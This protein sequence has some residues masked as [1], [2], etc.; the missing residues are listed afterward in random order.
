MSGFP[1]RLLFVLL[2]AF[3]HAG[4][5]QSSPA[6]CAHFS[7]DRSAEARKPD[8]ELAEARCH[9]AVR[10]YG[11]A[12][13]AVERLLALQPGD[14]VGLALREIVLESLRTIAPVA[15][16]ESRGRAN[17]SMQTRATPGSWSG[18]VGVRR[19][20]VAGLIGY[21][22]NLNLGTG[23]GE[24][25]L[26]LFR[27]VVLD[28]EDKL[29]DMRQRPSPLLGLNAGFDARR[30]WGEGGDLKLAGFAAARYNS[31]AAAYLPHDYRLEAEG[32]HQV[33][34]LRI[35]AAWA[36]VQRWIGRHRSLDA[37]TV[38]ASVEAPAP[39][40]LRIT[41]FVDETRKRLPVFDELRM[42]ERRYGAAIVSDQ[43][44][45]QLTLLSGRERATDARR[46]LDRDYTGFGLDWSGRVLEAWRLDLGYEQTRSSYVE[47][48]QL[49]LGHRLERFRELRVA[50]ER[51]LADAW[52]LAPR[53]IVQENRSN[54]VLT[55]FRR[56]QFLVELRRE[57]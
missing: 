4:S 14:R 10:Q 2:T 29:G 9:L 51:R 53:L 32:A 37:Q 21:D 44:P 35:A 3:S 24:V 31:R 57:F 17:E 49:F 34:T 1:K 43:L 50:F 54:V 6:D 8:V 20:W 47:Y 41:P 45:V 18:L 12:L 42:R 27:N 38:T 39:G 19:A 7:G 11:A 52:Y 28:I 56:H 22:S 25:S 13:L 55:E 33:G 36:T 26:P 15:P 16:N 23:A 40:G 48:S 30:A 46:Y 5:A